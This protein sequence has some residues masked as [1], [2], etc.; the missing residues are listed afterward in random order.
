M[1]PQFTILKVYDPL[2]REVAVLVNEEM[3][4]GT[5][6]TTFDASGLATG[7]YLYRLNAGGYVETHKMLLLR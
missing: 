1:N 4:P 2:G 5:Y 6:E 3:K 7:V